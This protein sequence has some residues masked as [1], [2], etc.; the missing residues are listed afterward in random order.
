MAPVAPVKAVDKGKV[1]GNCRDKDSVRNKVLELVKGRVPEREQTG[2]R[3]TNLVML[4]QKYKIQ[5]LPFL[6][7]QAGYLENALEQA[8]RCI[9]ELESKG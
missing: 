1:R 5:G 2:R 4:R 6:K 3:S 8:N 7:E 9:K